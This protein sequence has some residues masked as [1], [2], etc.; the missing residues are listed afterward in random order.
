MKHD[1]EEMFATM[2]RIQSEMQLGVFPLIK[3]TKRPAVK[4]SN[5]REEPAMN[6]ELEEW[7]TQGYTAYG[8]ACRSFLSNRDM[9]VID[10]DAYKD[11]PGCLPEHLP[12]IFK[13]DFVVATG[14]GLHIYK[15]IPE[16]QKITNYAGLKMGDYLFDIRG[17]ATA[18]GEYGGGYVVGPG[19][20]HE[21][22]VRL[23]TIYQDNPVKDLDMDWFNS[24]A[25]STKESITKKKSR[26]LE[27]AHLAA[28][29]QLA[30]GKGQG[31][32]DYI[33]SDAGSLIAG[34]KNIADREE[35]KKTLKKFLKRNE[36]FQDSY[37]E[38][39]QI[40]M[41][42]D[43]A[44]RENNKKVDAGFDSDGEPIRETAAVEYDLLKVSNAG[45]KLI[46]DKNS[47]QVYIQIG[48]KRNV[49]LEGTTGRRWLVQ[50][51]KPPTMSRVSNL[52]MR[53]DAQATE[54]ERISLLPRVAKDGN[55]VVYNLSRDD[56]KTVRVSRETNTWAVQDVGTPWF[57]SPAGEVEQT[58]PTPVSDPKETLMKLFDYANINPRYRELFICVVLSYFIPDID[59][60]IMYIYGEKGSGKS[61][62]AIFVK[63]LVDPNAI[64]LETNINQT[65][66]RE[67]K[68]TLSSSYLSVL[69]N[70]SF[71][72][73]G[74]SDLLATAAT[75]GG[76]RDRQLHTNKEIVLTS[77]KK[78]IIVTAV[79]QEAKREDLLSRLILFEVDK[80][81]KTSA[82]TKFFERFE[83]VRAEILGAVFEVL[84]KS[85]ILPEDEHD[86]IR[87]S[88]FHMYARSF[89]R[90]LG[91]DVEEI[92]ALLRENYHKQETQSV[93]QSEEMRLIKKLLKNSGLKVENVSTGALYDDLKALDS[94]FERKCKSSMVLGKRLNQLKG[95]AFE[96]DGIIIRKSP[97][98][99]RNWD[100]IWQDTS[101]EQKLEVN[102]EMPF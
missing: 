29:G 42:L 92:D 88:D 9:M 59:Y 83:H 53:L 20:L 77:M 95:S 62:A 24:I 98:N 56:G 39:E 79:N 72:S 69:D 90:Y 34:C 85:K 86:L 58:L 63:K 61:T 17:N 81:E 91:F 74:F 97:E 78:P 73:Q 6:H 31:L 94:S 49:P 70:L 19:S 68:V 30:K 33:L 16:G 67:A 22:G 48:G 43:I 18:N 54:S 76:F 5:Y 44:Q 57:L 32:Y 100:I 87:M 102:E 7:K 37:S 3:G 23:Y 38:Q 35:Y 12:E 60:P 28:M 64:E 65:D 13:D 51:I 36:Q 2:R 66:I 101:M 45:A 15:W 96:A 1:I 84:A 10:I 40:K 99:K 46:I 71:I 14:K 11:Q 55:D 8:V 41:F 82:K 75:G 93:E 21:K 52:I 50:T 4:W 26:E 27:L 80:L 47:E 25:G 89:A